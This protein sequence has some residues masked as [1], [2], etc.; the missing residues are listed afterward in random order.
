MKSE[1]ITIFPQKKWLDR[2]YYICGQ[3]SKNLLYRTIIH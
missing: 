2:V 3:M 1:G